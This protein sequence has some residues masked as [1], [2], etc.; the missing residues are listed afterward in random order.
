VIK[1]LRS[2]AL[3]LLVGASASCSDSG[4]RDEPPKDR[5]RGLV[6]ATDRPVSA[7][8]PAAAPS[9]AAPLEPTPAADPTP[10]PAEE[11]K[12]DEAPPRDYGAELLAAFGAPL[13]CL[14][15]RTDANA[16]AEVR[17]DVQAYLL[18][19]GYVSRAYVRA[20]ALDEPEVQCLTKRASSLR[21][22][23]P[24]EQAPRSVST[25]L[26]LTLKRAEK[27]AADNPP[28]G[29]DNAPQNPAEGAQNPP[30]NP[31]EADQKPLENP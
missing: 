28:A 12:K 30:E 31:P 4:S 21:L 11:E 22:A 13:D 8:Q 27:P 17:I 26:T 23:A 2:L 18:E 1:A 29:G 16:P 14:H 3:C 6:P 9:A 15:P 10:P 25:T 7:A 5:P 24:V 19:T 20:P